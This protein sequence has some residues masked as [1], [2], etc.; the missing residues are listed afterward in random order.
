MKQRFLLFSIVGTPLLVG[1]II[2]GYWFWADVV[3]KKPPLPTLGQVGE[4]SLLNEDSAFVG[5]NVLLGKITIADFI[6]TECAG[7]C[8]MMSAQMSE[9]QK[10]LSEEPNVQFA[11]FSVDPETDRPAVLTQYAKHYG[12]VKGKWMFL[13]GD[14][15]Q[16]YKL[17]REDFHLAVNSDTGEGGGILHSQKF[18]L[19]DNNATIRGYYDSEDTSAIS[20]LV[21]DAERL[22]NRVH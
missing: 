20:S 6:F 14:K 11:S 4:F 8:P 12:A 21:V 3:N 10:L 17:V 22:S 2:V 1:I 13:T 9:L 19:M 16:I 18:V 7:A 5:R 15:L